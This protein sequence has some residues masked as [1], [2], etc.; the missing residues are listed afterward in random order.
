MQTITVAKERLLST[1]RTNRDEHRELFLKAQALFREKLIEVLDERLARAR[2][3]DKVELWIRLPE[4]EDYT[5]QFD[6]AIA[7]VEWAEGD[8]IELSEKDFSRYVLGQ[9]E[10]AKAFAANTESY[11]IGSVGEG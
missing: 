9:W 6:Q 8:T 11:V 7:M 2:A 4:P 3:G 10:W 5:A 1:L